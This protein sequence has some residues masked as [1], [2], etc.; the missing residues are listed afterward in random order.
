[1]KLT[2]NET[3]TKTLT[4]LYRAIDK[5]FVVTL[6]FVDRDGEETIRTVE[7]HELRTTTDG[8]VILV[9]MCRL[10]G[11]ERQFRI[12][13]VRAYTVHRMPYV[14]TARLFHLIAAR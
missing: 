12:S 11:D 2:K 6:T 4:D 1:V 10:R 7:G 13:R 8:D 14:L 3:Q 5:G 9:A